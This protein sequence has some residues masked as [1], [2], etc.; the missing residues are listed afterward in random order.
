MKTRFSRR[1]AAA[2]AGLAAAGLAAVALAGPASAATTAP[3]SA[4]ASPGYAATVPYAPG[5]EPAA[6][7]YVSADR[8]QFGDRQREFG[9]TLVFLE[10]FPFPRFVEV[11]DVFD[12]QIFHLGFRHRGGPEDVIYFTDRGGRFRFHEVFDV[13]DAHVIDSPV[14]P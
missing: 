1:A 3:A 14:F 6:P 7:A 4:P 11:R 8:Q 2:L 12:V 9:E 5:Y 13:T 10:R